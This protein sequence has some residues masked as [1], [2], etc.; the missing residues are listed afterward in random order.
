MTIILIIVIQILVL[1]GNGV[2]SSNAQTLRP[3]TS[4]LNTNLLP[5][6][7]QNHQNMS[8]V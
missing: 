5:A 3:T 2:F 1:Y 8:N 4:A 6:V 7:P